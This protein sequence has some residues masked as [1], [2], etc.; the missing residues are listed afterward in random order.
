MPGTLCA[1]GAQQA[2]AVVGDDGGGRVWSLVL[3]LPSR[4]F[5]RQYCAP[6]S[7]LV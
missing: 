4:G 2:I 1:V 6:R 5:Q 3:S 7:G